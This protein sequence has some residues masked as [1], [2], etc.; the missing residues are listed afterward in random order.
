MVV[1]IIY[2]CT[3][4]WL[5]HKKSWPPL[6]STVKSPIDHK[7]RALHFP[8]NSL[9]AWL[10][11]HFLFHSLPPNRQSLNSRNSFLFTWSS[12]YESRDNKSTA[13]DCPLS[14]RRSK[15]RLKLKV[16]LIH[17][18]FLYFSA[19][20]TS[21]EEAPRKRFKNIKIFREAET[22]F[23]DLINSL[24][25]NCALADRFSSSP[26]SGFRSRLFNMSLY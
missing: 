10:K 17:L 25:H 2:C 24:R 18:N 4:C 8:R 22:F 21:E 13:F 19:R 20:S 3:S 16:F 14:H 1:W 23:L 7:V 6:R 11:W 26:P 5:L 15:S 9:P 12:T